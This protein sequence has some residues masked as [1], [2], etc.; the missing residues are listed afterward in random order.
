[1]YFT[2]LN[3]KY[4][5]FRLNFNIVNIL[6][7]S[8]LNFIRKYIIHFQD[9]TITIKNFSKL[10]KNFIESKNTNLIFMIFLKY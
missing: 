6:I 1:M 10:R 5:Y 4:F 8:I 3:N 7:Y 9:I 2:L